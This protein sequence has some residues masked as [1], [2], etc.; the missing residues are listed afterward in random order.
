MKLW[1]DGQCL[2]SSSRSRGIGRYLLGLIEGLHEHRDAVQVSISFN[3]AMPARAVEARDLVSRWIAPE[4]VH[5]WHGVA[6]A[7]EVNGGRTARRR[8]S[9]LA[10]AHHVACLSPDLALSASPFEGGWEAAVPLEPLSVPETPIASIFF[11]AIPAHFPDHYL[12][13]EAARA[14]YRRRLEAHRDFAMNFCISA[15][16]QADLARL[17]GPVHS[18]NIAAGVSTKLTAMAGRRGQRD[19]QGHGERRLLVVGGLDW[20]KNVGLVPDALARIPPELAQ[21]VTL[22]VAGEA[23]PEAV[24]VLRNRW[25]DCGL[26]E[27]ALQIVGFVDDER[28]VDLYRGARALVLPSLLEGFGLTALE[29][30]ACGTVALGANTGAIP[31]V[32]GDGDLLFDPSRPDELAARLEKILRDDAFVASCGRAAAARASTFSW[33]RTASLLL[34]AA[35]NVRRSPSARPVEVSTLRRRMAAMPA[36]PKLPRRLIAGTMARAEPPR[37]TPRLIIDDAEGRLLPSDESP[38]LVV[39]GTDRGVR[40]FQSR[41]VYEIL[42][43]DVVCLVGTLRPV[44]DRRSAMIMQARLVGALVVS[45]VPD[46]ESAL[47]QENGRPSHWLEASIAQCCGFLCA[48]ETVARRLAALL[49]GRDMPR[50]MRLGVLAIER[51]SLDEKIAAI[52]R[53]VIQDDWWRVLAQAPPVAHRGAD[54]P[55]S[56]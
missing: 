55:S 38:V 28:L 17:V 48:S 39:E 9:E 49:E 1:I 8:L 23:G 56:A 52:W 44:S 7:G 11:D 19:A 50:A 4:R 45:L 36:M 32:I 3:A 37:R 20:R 12:P 30:M 29:A 26:P 41:I 14:F 5:L 13:D 46:D 40:C 47:V 51:R 10:L 6:E 16:S 15:Y 42:P 22:L 25:R 54:S 34:R 35:R 27:A 33:G 31:E 21:G 53:I 2:Q 24:A 18:T 43:G